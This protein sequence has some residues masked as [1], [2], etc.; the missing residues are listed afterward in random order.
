VTGRLWARR[1]HRGAELG[2]Q[3]AETILVLCRGTEQE[4]RATCERLERAT[5]EVV[6]SRVF[7]QERTSNTVSFSVL[8]L[9]N[10]LDWRAI[11]CVALR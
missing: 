4:I 11:D 7:F 10:I 5:R 8:F 9:Q 2:W 1:D 3:I 6:D